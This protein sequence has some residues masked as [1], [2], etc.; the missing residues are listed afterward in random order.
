MVI[1][2]FLAELKRNVLHITCT[3]ASIVCLFNTP[4]AEPVAKMVVPIKWLSCLSGSGYQKCIDFVG[5]AGENRISMKQFWG[6]GTH[7]HTRMHA[8]TP[9]RT[10]ESAHASTA[11]LMHDRLLLPYRKN[12]WLNYLVAHPHPKHLARWGIAD[13]R[14]HKFLQNET[15]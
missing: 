7:T 9:A 3:F 12:C 1:W 13:S 2:F 11:P 10:H 8:R 6:F 5:A 15:F 4:T 14:R